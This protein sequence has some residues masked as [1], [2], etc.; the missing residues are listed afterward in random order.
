MV[1][2]RALGLGLA[3]LTLLL[4]LPV[5]QH[6][7]INYDDP[8]YITENPAVLSGITPG[9]LRWAFTHVHASN[10]HPLTWIS[11]MLDVEWFG[12]DPGAHHL[13][14][15]LLHALNAALLFA[16]LHGVS[17]RPW[18]ALLVAAA[19]AW[20]PLR[21][22]SV[23]WAAERKDVLSACFG[24]LALLA[25]HR[26][27][28]RTRLL[29]ARPPTPDTPAP[30]HSSSRYYALAL[31]AFLLSLLC[32]PM[33]VT[34][35]FL[36]LLLDHWPL[37]RVRPGH[38]KNEWPR[39]ALEKWPFFLGSAAISV[40]TW[41][42]Q[43]TEAVISLDRL[44][45]A[46]RLANAALAYVGYLTKTLWPSNLS[47]LYPL[48]PA[49]SWTGAALAT[50]FL[51]GVTI[52]VWRARSTRPHWL[53]GWLWFLGTLVPVIGIVQ[54]GGQAMADR[55]TYLPLIGPVWA[56]AWELALWAARGRSQKTTIAVGCAVAL[57]VSAGLTLREQS[58][59]RDSQ[60]LFER[61]L[62]VT[63][64]N[65][66]AH[67]NLG[68]AYEEAG[69]FDDAIRQYQA[70]VRI[71][72]HLAQA[73]NNLGGLLSEAGRPDEAETHLREAIRLKPRSWQAH[74][75]LATAL[76]KLG[77]TDEASTHYQHAAKLA[78]GDPRP[79]YATARAWLRLGQTTQSILS[80]QQALRLDPN[81]LPS[82]VHLARTLAS[83][84]DPGLRDGPQAVILAE[85]A[86]RL[87]QASDAFVL[88]TLAMAL[89]ETKNFPAARDT[90][91][92]AIEMERVQP[93]PQTL[94][95]LEARLSLYQK[96]EPYRDP[97]LQPKPEPG[98]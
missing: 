27:T 19:F 59:W 83:H 49:T 8:D 52:A 12:L 62:T 88:D 64:N 84:P 21:V 94:V 47:V 82:L 15:A 41:F 32:K 45:L 5:S 92:R 56:A 13:V 65:A 86:A 81:H 63:A 54:V 26:Y 75:N 66:V 11:H 1:R 20:H 67:S 10:W 90:L 29:P 69:R 61:A 79:P 71:H 76:V 2:P 60:T 89:A 97:S 30:T 70:A 4:F 38:E 40:V 28:L 98:R 25:Y 46:D 53:V 58:F 6:E 77:R 44:P 24:L 72:P 96:S 18:L 7:F 87:S 3:L 68:L 36:L 42:A 74:I 55:Y 43:R 34:L 23:A 33:L 57:A 37:Q 91:L 73:H 80:F 17:R 9:G 48:P 51:V 22:Q 31:A 95:E 39:L 93:D 78:P 85:R 50:A 35:P 16:F 14:N